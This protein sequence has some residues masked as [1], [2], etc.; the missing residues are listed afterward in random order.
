MKKEDQWIQTYTGKKFYPMDSKVEDICIEDIAHSL[1]LL[2]RF[3][4]HCTEFYSVA[5]HSVFVSN[6]VGKRE[7]KTDIFFKRL[8][9][10]GLLHDAAEAYLGDIVSPIKTPKDINREYDILQM[11]GLAVGWDAILLNGWQ[12]VKRVDKFALACE[13]TVLMSHY[14]E[15]PGITN[16]DPMTVKIIPQ[17]PK[18]AE[19]SF[20][21]RFSELQE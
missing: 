11:V 14:L 13:K 10:L 5:Q 20:L 2:C 1:S 6:L 9:R 15:W 4:G 7:E 3:N 8:A 18:E 16:V 17:S 21:K 12:E 19:E